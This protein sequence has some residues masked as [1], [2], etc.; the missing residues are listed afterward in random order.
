[1]AYHVYVNENH[2]SE[3][4]EKRQVYEMDFKQ[5]EEFRKLREKIEKLQKK[6]TNGLKKNR[7]LSLLNSLKKLRIF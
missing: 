6:Q 7:F 2:D 4:F 5:I 1:M 3:Q